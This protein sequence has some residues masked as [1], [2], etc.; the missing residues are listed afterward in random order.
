[1]ST[2]WITSFLWDSVTFLLTPI[3]LV[4]TLALFQE[5]GWS[6]IDELGRVFAILLIYGV[7]FLPI[8]F[9]ASKL[10]SVSSTGFVIMTIINVFTG[11][12]NISLFKCIHK[13]NLFNVSHH[14]SNR[15]SGSRCTIN[16]CTKPARNGKN[17]E[18][19]IL[20]ISNFLF[21]L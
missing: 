3:L 21:R 1:M 18:K 6:K 2:Y 20:H 7:A 10:F 9:V 19:H 15:Y 14:R 5:E 16:S 13:L 11:M 8:T 4:A 12:L 17:I